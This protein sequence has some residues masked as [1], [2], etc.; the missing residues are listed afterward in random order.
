LYA[1]VGASQMVNHSDVFF[2]RENDKSLLLG[3]GAEY[4]FLSGLALR[5]ELT[6]YDID[7]NYA[8]LSL[9][10]RFGHA[11]HKQ[12]FSVAAVVPPEPA[13]KIAEMVEPVAKE[14]LPFSRLVKEF[15]VYFATSQ[16]AFNAE[17][18][19]TIDALLS[20][21]EQNPEYR[22][23]L[24][25]Y[26]DVRGESDTNITLANDRVV[27]VKNALLEAG[28]AESRL[29]DKTEGETALFGSTQTGRGLRENRRVQ[30]TVLVDE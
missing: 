9:L 29:Q 27:A 24:V 12:P 4:G 19:R 20:F 16:S 6:S 22:L 2:V 23:V 3:F 14:R 7:S 15:T 30:I 8:G 13:A 5:A 26:A 17:S 21:I 18:N 11:T 1:R 25:G 28:I 10:Y